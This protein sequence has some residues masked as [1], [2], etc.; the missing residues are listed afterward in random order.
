ML[1]YKIEGD[2]DYRTVISTRLHH[3][4]FFEQIDEGKRISLSAAW[5]N[6]RLEPG[7]WCEEMAEVIG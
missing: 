6:P 7:P 3:T 5:V 2:A 1:R 4:L